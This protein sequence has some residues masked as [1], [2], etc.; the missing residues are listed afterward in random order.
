MLTKQNHIK[1]KKKK[2]KNRQADR[3][4]III[5]TI[6]VFHHTRTKITIFHVTQ[7]FQLATIMERRNFM[8]YRHPTSAY[9]LKKPQ[10]TIILQSC[11]TLGTTDSPEVQSSPR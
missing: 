1:K 4:K 10:S 9:H 7:L 5:I 3:S 6:I 8:S 11:K 2:A